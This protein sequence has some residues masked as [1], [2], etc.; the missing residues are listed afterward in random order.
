MFVNIH[1]T[2]H[3]LVISSVSHIYGLYTVLASSHRISAVNFIPRTFW[4]YGLFNCSK[5]VQ[6]IG[7]NHGLLKPLDCFET[8][9][10]DNLDLYKHDTS[11][12]TYT[13]FIIIA[14]SHNETIEVHTKQN[15]LFIVKD[16]T[17][18]TVM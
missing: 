12:H 16:R 2:L 7:L 6:I 14:Y 10:V 5:M 3:T 11:H 8:E 18:K 1:V 4:R 9:D 17:P 15:K 13:R